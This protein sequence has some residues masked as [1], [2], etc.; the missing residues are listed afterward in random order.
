MGTVGEFMESPLVTWVQSFA[1]PSDQA[2]LQDLCDGTFLNDV[3]LLIDPE[4]PEDKQ[5]KRVVGDSNARLQNWEILIRNIT[6]YYQAVL[7]QL[8]TMRLPNILVISKDNNKDLS[9][10]EVE[11]VLL[12]ILGCAIQC[13]RKEEYINNIK[14]LDITVQ[15]AIVEHIKQISEGS[16]NVMTLNSNQD[17]L[18]TEVK[19]QLKQLVKE[20]DEYL[21][22]LSKST[23]D[24]DYF[25]SRAEGRGKHITP[26]IGLEKYHLTEEL[27]DSRNKVKSLSEELEEKSKLVS[28]L[29][30]DLAESKSTVNRLRTE[31]SRLLQ[32][33]REA[34]SYKDELEEWKNKVQN[35]KDQ[36]AELKKSQERMQELDFYKSRVQELREEQ[37][38][39]LK[40]KC[41][42]EDR[43][44][45]GEMRVQRLVAELLQ[46]QIL[47]DD[48]NKEKEADRKRIA[49][50]VEEN[51]SL[52]FSKL[53]KKQGLG[54]RTESEWS[55]PKIGSTT[56]LYRMGGQP[57]SAELSQSD[58]DTIT[59]L[60]EAIDE[61]HAQLE[62]ARDQTNN[63]KC[64]NLDT[65]KQSERLQIELKMLKNKNALKSNRTTG[66]QTDSSWN[67][68][69]KSTNGSPR[70]NDRPAFGRYRL[71]ENAKVSN[72][73]IK[74]EHI[75]NKNKE[76][77]KGISIGVQTL[78]SWTEYASDCMQQ[79]PHEINND[80]QRSEMVQNGHHNSPHDSS[81]PA[82]HSSMPAHH[83][84]MPAHHSSM[85]AHHSSMPAHHSSMPAHH[86]SMTA[87][88]R[89]YRSELELSAIEEENKH[90]AKMVERMQRDKQTFEHL[91]KQNIALVHEQDI[92]KR[93]MQTLKEDSKITVKALEDEITAL[94]DT[95]DELKKKNEEIEE[96]TEQDKELESKLIDILNKSST[97]P[98]TPGGTTMSLDRRNIWNYS[99]GSPN[100][101]LSPTSPSS[102]SS[103]MYRIDELKA[104]RNSPNGRHSPVI[105][106]SPKVKSKGGLPFMRSKSFNF[107]SRSTPSVTNSSP[108][109]R[110]DTEKK[111]RGF[112]STKKK[113][114]TD[115]SD[116]ETES[117]K[118][119]Y[120][121]TDNL[122]P[123][124]SS[125]GFTPVT[126]V[127]NPAGHGEDV[128]VSVTADSDNYLRTVIV[129]TEML[130]VEY[131][132]VKK[133]RKGSN[134][135]KA[136][137]EKIMELQ[138][139]LQDL[140]MENNEL[141]RAFGPNH[142]TLEKFNE[143]EKRNVK[144]ETENR[145]LQKIIESWQSAYG[146]L[147]PYD[148]R[149]YH[150]FTAL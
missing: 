102:P 13:E 141:K 105:P 37:D 93:S 51:N 136:F 106:E 56:D 74:T 40:S 92:M 38:Q 99:R 127:S 42:L 70:N 137:V 28:D 55:L 31:S 71:G 43:V 132:N 118:E 33:S 57:I 142:V 20:R 90:L 25:R 68:T 91:Q 61:L 72:E 65:M 54:V 145:R 149:E 120:G 50:L 11:K 58:G 113:H 60:Q 150:Y 10:R 95:I 134:K 53:H 114:N 45:D 83:S 128:C 138:N 122:P 9:I 21:E 22:L 3:M 16:G 130:K 19:G 6:N 46:N 104:P 27:T 66:M 81:M 121:S 17:D 140:A 41:Q 64:K 135:W 80:I 97:M 126:M 69:S 117:G 5:L 39:M 73:N 32:E 29:Q 62:V 84:S 44:K 7:Q 75:E 125:K 23:Q 131:N 123:G 148:K 101:N 14:Q 111:K 133:H 15:T 94:N 67:T 26:P 78:E 18:D 36:E 87:P 8:I 86:S 79:P 98:S 2:D 88:P 63:E 1:P 30:T 82:H 4:R 89:G 112:F 24:C 116:S 34:R 129:A 143:L 96:M 146:K 47:I 107:G 108:L 49:E 109:M 76:K 147:N 59:Q 48:I 110:S 52:V 144:L 139:R 103:H 115:V 35:L 119:N 12:L 77:N 100:N 85:P 124:V